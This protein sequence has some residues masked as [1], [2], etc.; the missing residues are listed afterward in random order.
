M[1]C[2]LTN[3]AVSLLMEHLV[4]VQR[5]KAP[6]FSAFHRSSQGSLVSI[7]QPFVTY[8]VVQ[9]PKRTK[10]SLINRI[11]PNHQIGLGCAGR[12]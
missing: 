5:Q 12:A 10:T 2:S 7:G 11:G 8:R 9:L 3:P 4:I 1:V 6:N